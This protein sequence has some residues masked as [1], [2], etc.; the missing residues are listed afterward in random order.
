MDA[1]F[2][3]A[4][5]H[6]KHQLDVQLTQ[7]K[8]VTI[9]QTNRFSVPVSDKELKEKNWKLYSKRH[10]SRLSGLIPYVAFT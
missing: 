10:Q 4:S 3:A 9:S 8:P 5:Q 7:S 2:P 1:L 6:Y